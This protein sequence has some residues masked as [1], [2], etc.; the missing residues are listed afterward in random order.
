M[1]RDGPLERTVARIESAHALDGVAATVRSVVRKV[2]PAGPV[3]D[4]L[5]GKPLGHPLHAALVAVPIGAWTSSIVI[6][7][8]GDARAARQLTALGCLA[9]L[10]AAA[11][12][13]ADWM[14]TDGP[15]RRV[16]LV[17]ALVND[18]ALTTFVMSWRARGRGAHGRGLL[19]SLLG[20]GLVTAGGWLG[21]HLAYVLGVG[22]D[23]ET[24]REI[25]GTS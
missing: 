7:L 24:V 2:I 6:D 22:V 20:G 14:S 25:V 9:A 12:G 17:H 15:Q 13:A 19:L 11:A 16:G 5:R 1:G 21:G 3:E 8:L 23:V 18:A 4:V 10:P